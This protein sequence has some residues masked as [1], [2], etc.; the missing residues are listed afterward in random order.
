MSNKINIAYT[1]DDNYIN[2]TI[3]SMQSVIE[4]NKDCDI[5]FIIGYSKLS[6]HSLSKLK[7]MESN[8]NCSIRFVKIDEA[9]F[10]GMTVSCWVTIQAWFRIKIP[11]LCPDLDKILYLDCDTLIN[12]SIIN[13]WNIDLKNNYL[14]AV[15]DIINVDKH[16]KRLKMEDN[17]YFNS[18]VLLLNCVKFREDDVFHKIKDITK[19]NLYDI[20]YC[21]Q[22]TLNIIADSKKID[23]EKKYNYMELWNNNGYFEYF[24]E[25]EKEYIKAR[26]NPVI[27]HMVG[28]KPTHKACKHSYLDS[29]WKYAKETNIYDELFETYN[30][31]EIRKRSNKII[32]TIFS[33]YCEYS[34]NKKWRVINFLGIKFKINVSKHKRRINKSD[35]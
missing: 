16:I 17:Y 11:E 1:P 30:N 9:D 2:L 25:E 6:N 20:L 22:D 18:G 34:R 14:A 28:T 23:L 24:D 4:N 5:E 33:V 32:K 13:L 15:K 10:Q 19:S 35:K 12:D 26:N 7:W 3:V 29:W 27:I 8:K 21:D 31:S